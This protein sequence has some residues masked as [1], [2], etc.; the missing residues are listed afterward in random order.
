MTQRTDPSEIGRI[1]DAD[2]RDPAA[3]NELG[4]RYNVAPTQPVQVVV[5]RDDGRF[6]ELHRWGLVP[7]WSKTVAAGSRMINARA[8]TLAESPAFRPSF[9]RRRCLIPSDGF[10]EWRRASRQREPF[11]FHTADDRPLAFAGIWA[12]WRDS[13]SGDWLLSC[14]VVTTSANNVVATLHDRMPAILGDAEWRLWL[15]PM[16]TD[17]PLL[18]DLLQPAA[19]EL[20]EVRPASPLVNSPN[21]EGPELLDSP[22]T[23][24]PALTLFGG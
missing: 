11:L 3:Q 16:I 12:P 5:Q 23:A 1:F 14:A 4:P 7:A 21:N 13:A 19:D 15:D 22:P 20:L 17:M 8:E 2:V 6:V 10:Y 18:L 24:G 9:L